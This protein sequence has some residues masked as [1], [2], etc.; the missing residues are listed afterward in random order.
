VVG[1]LSTLG[2]TGQPSLIISPRAKTV[3]KGMGGGYHYARVQV[4]G[5]ERF[6]DEPV[7]NTY[8]HVCEALQYL[9]VG[10][11][12]DYKALDQGTATKTDAPQSPKSHTAIGR[13]SPHGPR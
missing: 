6:R 3:R 1:Q 2:M 4:S 7:K 12:M 10:E 8:S 11:G 5:E 9:M 13:R